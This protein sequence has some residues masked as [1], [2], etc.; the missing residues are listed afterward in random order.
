MKK[1]SVLIIAVLIVIIGGSAVLYNTLKDQVELPDPLAQQPLS[2]Q[3]QSPQEKIK[4][5]DFTVQDAAGNKVNLSDLFG[6]PIVLNF[7]ASWCPPCK[8][9]MPDFDEVYKERGS[10]IQFVML[11]AVDGAHETKESGQSYIAEQGF[12]FPV[13]FD[14]EQDAV[15]Q[16]GIR[17]YPTTVFIDSNGFVVT[18]IEGSIDQATLRKGIDMTMGSESSG[19]GEYRTISQKDAK[20][21]MDDSAPYTLLDVRSA[22]EFKEKH[23]EGAVLIP[24]NEIPQL[25]GAKL[26][27]KDALILVYCRSGYRSALA[28]KALIGLGY[29]NVLD[30]GG[31]ESWPYET[32]SGSK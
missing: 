29:T 17:A 25:A 1:K 9:E 2:T 31:I 24:D 19:A 12:T 11:N 26:P 7:W 20:A 30:F 8:S 13:Y 15:R 5:A 27:E 4:A 10:E 21:I 3:E 6:K 14:T 22:D 32:V 18:S 16:Y 28:A 23:I